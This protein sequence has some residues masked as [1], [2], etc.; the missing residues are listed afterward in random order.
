MISERDAAYLAQRGI[1]VSHAG[2]YDL[3]T[4]AADKLNALFS[5]SDLTSGGLLFRYAVRNGSGVRR[6]RH[7]RRQGSLPW[8]AAARCSNVVTS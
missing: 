4:V 1:S 7:S 5:R 6:D 8:I 3:R 2:R